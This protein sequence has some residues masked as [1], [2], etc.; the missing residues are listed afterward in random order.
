MAKREAL[1]DSGKKPCGREPK[2]PSAA[3]EAKDQVNF[4]NEESRII[5]NL[6]IE[7]KLLP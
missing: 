1:V 5:P 7:L 3:P 4:T 2:A 6:A